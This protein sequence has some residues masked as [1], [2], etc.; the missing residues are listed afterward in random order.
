MSPTSHR[1]VHGGLKVDSELALP[2]ARAPRRPPPVDP[3][4]QIVLAAAGDEDGDETVLEERRCRFTVPGV[5]R[6]EICDGSIM[7][8]APVP[9]APPEMIAP[10]VLGTAWGALLQQRGELAL[11]GGVVAVDGG[12]IAFCGPS[13]A[14]KSTTV[15]WWARRGHRVV[16]DDLCRVE[17]PGGGAPRVWPSIARLKLSGEARQAAGLGGGGSVP[18]AVDGKFHIPVRGCD[19]RA[20]LPL[21][22]VYLLAWGEHAV[23]R[24]RGIEAL[25]RLHDDAAYRIELL[26]A[27]AVSRQWELCA[28]VARRVPVWELSRPR[29]WSALDRAMSALSEEWSDG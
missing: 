10:F 26:V 27:S 5:G 20:P 25:R 7:S 11:H 22:A 12:A 6:Y 8:V 3:D 9:G 28:D 21:Q 16:S 13:T 14:G 29:E 19:D 2:V 1:Y 15:A 23:R 4:V 24:L 18:A 17:V